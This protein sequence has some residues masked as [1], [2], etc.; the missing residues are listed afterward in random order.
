ML[1]ESQQNAFKK[2][3]QFLLSSDD[4]YLTL[5]APA[6]YGKSY[7]L[8]YIEQEWKNLNN[9]RQFL[10]MDALNNIRFGCTTNKAAAVLNNS[11]TVHKMFGLVPRKNFKTG[12]TFT[13]TTSKTK[14]VGND[15]III[16]E[17]SMIDTQI[18]EIIGKYTQ[19]AKVIFVG[20]EY[21]LPPIGSSKVPVF[22]NG[23][24]ETTLTEPMRQDKDS[25]LFKEI[26]RLRQAVIDGKFYQVQAGEGITFLNGRDFKDAITYSFENQEDARVLAYT[27]TQ[28]EGYNKFIRRHLH[29]VTDFR[30]GDL[31]VAANCCLESSKVEQTYK[32]I[33]ITKN[34]VTLD[35]NVTY[36]IP[37]D[38][39]AWFKAIKRA[40]REGKKGGDWKQFFY[41][42]EGF[43]DIRD[44]FSCTVN[45]SQGST[46]DKV[47]IDAQNL[48]SCFNLS[49]LLRLLYVAHSRARTEVIIYKG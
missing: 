46:Y 28:V 14:D 5:S 13:A 34:T 26:A 29:G 47:F 15:L 11:T 18:L 10:Q 41:L 3:K 1:N 23:Y 25:H 38:K 17:S 40:E 42:K 6:G 8:N 2:I 31:V 30:E 27:N 49:T 32:I 16:D 7:L 43:L 24:T 12:Q 36:P 20:D 19:T 48:H 9:Q 45:K 44:G 35:D 37:E 4:K 21:Q 33:K 39:E 22:S